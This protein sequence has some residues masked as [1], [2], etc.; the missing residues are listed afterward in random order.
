MQLIHAVLIHLQSRLK[1]ISVSGKSYFILIGSLIAVSIVLFQ[2]P[3][4]YAINAPHRFPGSTSVETYTSLTDKVNGTLLYATEIEPGHHIKFYQFDKDDIGVNETFQIDKHTP[5]LN[6]MSKEPLSF[7]ALFQKIQPQAEIPKVLAEADKYSKLHAK[8]S[9]EKSVISSTNSSSNESNFFT[10][11]KNNTGSY[12]LAGNWQSWQDD[13]VWF[14]NNFCNRGS[15]KFCET[16]K[17]TFRRVRLTGRDVQVAG[18]AAGMDTTARFQ[19]RSLGVG[20]FPSWKTR[21]EVVVQPR[22][23]KQWSFSKS[24]DYEVWLEPIS[25][26]RRVHLAITYNTNSSSGQLPYQQYEFCIGSVY[27]PYSTVQMYGKDYNDAE[28]VLRRNLQPLGAGDSWQVGRG[29]CRGLQ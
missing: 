5:I 4:I 27:T 22:E 15:S 26:E 6:G 3:F 20:L 11:Q 12:Y 8:E 19:V 7:V 13:A 14:I 18:M 23:I 2:A 29:K 1:T 25:G 24:N 9:K 28:T 21:A 10:P 17:T 16:N